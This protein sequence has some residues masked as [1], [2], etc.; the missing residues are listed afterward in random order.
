MKKLYFSFYFRMSHCH[1]KMTA[2]ML[3]MFALNGVKAQIYTLKVE[4]KEVNE[5]LGLK[6]HLEIPTF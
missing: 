2:L 6:E 1:P 3:F 4:P 5:I